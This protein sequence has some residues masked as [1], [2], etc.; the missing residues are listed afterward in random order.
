MTIE[1]E[2]SAFDEVDPPDLETIGGVDLA[3]L[4]DDT[5]ELVTI[6]L[7]TGSLDPEN[8]GRLRACE[9]ELR[10]VLA[11]T[12]E[13]QR[14]YLARLHSLARSVSFVLDRNRPGWLA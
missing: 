10:S 13:P 5:A 14:D 1:E 6:F 7:A 3:M 11:K 4:V 9:A 2:W 8:M 12:A